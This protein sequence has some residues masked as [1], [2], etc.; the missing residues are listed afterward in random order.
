[1]LFSTKHSR[2]VSLEKYKY[3]VSKHQN[4]L[5]RETQNFQHREILRNLHQNQYDLFCKR[6]SIRT[7]K[8]H[9]TDHEKKTEN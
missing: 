4:V 7:V 3:R 6:L 9:A 8:T 5:D 2:C 1:M